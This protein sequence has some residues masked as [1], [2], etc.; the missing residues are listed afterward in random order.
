VSR[1]Q[2]EL[3]A[4][5]Q[6]QREEASRRQRA[7]DRRSLIVIAGG[8]LLAL[9]L[10]FGV[11]L[12]LQQREP[13]HIAFNT[14]TGDVGQHL[15][16]EGR[17]HVQPDGKVEYKHYPPASGPHFDQRAGAPVPWQT[18]GTLAEGIYLH[19]LEH[20]GIAVLYN[21]PTGPDCDKLRT[22]L[23]K[24]VLNL[25]PADPQFHENKIVMTPYSRGMEDHKIALVAWDW[26]DL[27]D[28][29]DEQRITRFYEAHVNKGP[30]VIP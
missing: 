2:R 20:G 10:I 22:Q 11:A 1:T 14:V 19:N 23:E 30:E 9:V 29:Y 8:I 15:E 25:V 6:A 28:G 21:C 16:D 24:Y 17:G 26:I 18:I 4:L 5:R 13:R 3:K 12:Y 27:L 7:R